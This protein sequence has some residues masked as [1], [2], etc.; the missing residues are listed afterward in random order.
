[1]SQFIA[2]LSAGILATVLGCGTAFLPTT[3]AAAPDADKAVVRQVTA[4]C[5]AQVKEQAHYEELAWH[6]RHKLVKECVK[7]TLAKPH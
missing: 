2:A 6:A 7:E 4:S 5:K 3:A 1:M